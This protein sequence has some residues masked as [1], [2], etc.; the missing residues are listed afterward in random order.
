[1]WKAL[2]DGVPY[3]GNDIC[4]LWV[5]CMG[6]PIPESEYRY[7]LARGLYAKRWRP[8]DPAAD[9]RRPVDWLKV[10]LPKARPRT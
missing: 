9:P 7:L 10:K 8:E 6:H 5:W 2:I 4:H 1:V 3:T